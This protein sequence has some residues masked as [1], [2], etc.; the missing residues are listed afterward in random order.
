M[1]L[2]KEL[3]YVLGDNTIYVVGALVLGILGAVFN[4]GYRTGVQSSFV[5]KSEMCE[6][7]ILRVAELD[8]SV[9]LCETQRAKEVLECKTNCVS[10]VCRPLCIQDVKK[11]IE[12]YKKMRK[13]K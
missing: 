12:D 9:T 10:K 6:E 13:C 4:L 2:L 3:K 11:S 5:P 8:S 1:K 7:Y